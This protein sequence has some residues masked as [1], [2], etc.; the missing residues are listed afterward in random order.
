ML[1]PRKDIQAEEAKKDW[2]GERAR[3]VEAIQGLVTAAMQNLR[4]IEEQVKELDEI[5]SDDLL[6][7]E[8]DAYIR[9]RRRA[10]EA[11]NLVEQ[12]EFE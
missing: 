10:A 6:D 3:S 5:D 1:T 8:K 2:K 4:E 11:K 9:L 12:R 7:E